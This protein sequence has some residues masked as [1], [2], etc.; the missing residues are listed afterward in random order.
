ML[1]CA[2]SHSVT[3]VACVCECRHDI[4]CSIVCV[5]EENKFPMKFFVCVCIGNVAVI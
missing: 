4:R 3:F 5:R 2:C 1:F